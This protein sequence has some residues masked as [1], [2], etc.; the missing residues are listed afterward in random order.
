MPQGLQKMF[1][2]VPRTYE[3]INFLLTLG[4]DRRWRRRA[5]DL[6]VSS[7]GNRWLDVCCGTGDMTMQLARRAA[8]VG[9]IQ[10]HCSDFSQ[11]MMAKLLQKSSPVTINATLSNVRYLP[12]R[13]Q[14]FDL[15]TISFASRNINV[16]RER[17]VET[18]SE[19]R[20]ILRPGGRFVNLETSQ[21]PNRLWR[22][23]VHFFVKLTVYPTGG[24]L[25]GAWTA[26]RYLSQT[27]P[28]FYDADQ[29]ATILKEAGFDT[30]KY[31]RLLSG[32]AAVHIAYRR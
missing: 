9:G 18:F 15:V 27:I 16:T 11:P 22:A 21:P 12:Y 26:Y 29:L 25:S 17:F 23:L 28:R 6:A 24:A 2:D 32:V 10:I 14:T 7:G 1:A 8:R 5:A 20:R 19:F 13:D 31:V 4:F 30:V 3:M